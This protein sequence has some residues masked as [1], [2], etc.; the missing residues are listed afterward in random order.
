[1]PNSECYPY[2]EHACEQTR[3]FS[4]PQMVYVTLLWFVTFSTAAST[5]L[6]SLMC[7]FVPRKPMTRSSNRPA[8]IASMVEN[9]ATSR[10]ESLSSL[11]KQY[12]EY[13]DCTNTNREM[14]RGLRNRDRANLLQM[15][16]KTAGYRQPQT[17]ITPK[18]YA[19]TTYTPA[20]H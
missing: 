3:G 11:P 10:I 13:Q 14:R 1:M 6:H 12:Y 18:T 20:S 5:V 19:L 4:R 8:S 17:E 2:V 9:G 15:G 16:F 7:A